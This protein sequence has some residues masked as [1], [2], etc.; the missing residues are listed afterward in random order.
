M[1]YS[2]VFSQKKRQVH[3]L[4]LNIKRSSTLVVLNSTTMKHFFVC[5][6]IIAVISSGFITPNEK[7]ATGK[8]TVTVADDFSFLRAHRQGKGITLT[9]GVTSAAS[10]IGFDIE[11]TM[12]DPND[13]YS[14]WE[15]VATVPGSSTRSFKYTDNSVLPGTTNYR[16]TAWY[17]DGRSAT[18]EIVSVKIMGH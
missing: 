12:Q 16:I 11:K 13:P 3:C 4:L 9:W 17:S 8:A 1:K 6:A 15:P 14:V 10:L 18:S 7:P 5:T 2:V